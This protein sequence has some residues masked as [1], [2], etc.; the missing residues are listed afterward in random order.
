MDVE[1]AA[2]CH[3]KVVAEP[4]IC[5]G[6]GNTAGARDRY[7]TVKAIAASVVI[8]LLLFVGLL[9]VS[10]LGVPERPTETPS[11]GTLVDP[12]SVYDPVDV[13][14]PL[15]VGFRQLLRRDGILPVYDPQFV[16]AKDSGWSDGTLV[17]GLELDGQSRAYPVGFLNRRE[18]VIDSVAGIPVLVT[19]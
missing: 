2:W 19:W 12:G 16:A 8:V 17:I 18:M 5:S 14:D 13:G 9:A 11:L 10:T 3:E 4:T 7:T 1:G 15:P 6:I